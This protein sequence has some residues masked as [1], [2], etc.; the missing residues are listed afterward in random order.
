M[1]ITAIIPTFNEEIHIEDAIKSVGFAD[2]I[3][4]I[5]SFSTDKTVSLANKHKVRL[6]QRVF[7]DFSSQKNFAIE[8]ATN[9]WIYLL[10]A[11]ERVTP[12]LKEEIL[13]AV[14]DPKD[15]VGFFVYRT[16]Y[17][18]GRKINYSG[19]QRDKVARLFNRN[20]CKYNGNLVHEVIKAN[21]KLGFFKNK[22]EHYSYRG[23]DHYISKLNQ[24]AWL[25]AEQLNRKGKKVNLYHIFIKPPARF[26][27]HY[28]IR[29]G[30]LD[31]F[32]G[33]VIAVT[34]SYGVLTRYIKLW[35][36]NHKLR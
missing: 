30:V 34:Q 26:L 33:F 4:V 2:E 16:F 10:D 32:P 7:D 35:L 36:L 18:G 17:F 24:Y 3:I 13:E 20:F 28:F 6:I 14:K 1:K 11:D 27:I 23:F 8:Q 21:G 12:N 29:L 25:Q 15:F 9:D 5:D 19:W 31:G 22:L